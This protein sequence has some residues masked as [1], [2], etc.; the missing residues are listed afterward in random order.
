[1]AKNK[2]ELRAEEQKVAYGHAF[3]VGDAFLILFA[4]LLVAGLILLTAV[5]VPAIRENFR[6]YNEELRFTVEVPMT[7]TQFLPKAGDAWI[8]LDS[9]DAVCTVR[10]VEYSQETATCRVTLLRKY[11]T[12]REGEG[13]MIEGTR[14]AVGATLYFRCGPERYYAASVSGVVSDRF[15]VPET[16]AE[17]ESLTDTPTEEDPAGETE[18]ATEEISSGGNEVTDADSAGIGE[19]D[20]NGE[21]T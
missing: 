2:R 9:G 3:H 13:Y 12:Y 15:E 10:T 21:N 8:L 1:M 19:E 16:T 6:E 7:D 5:I 17:S 11:A 20:P 18:G 14:I 4:I